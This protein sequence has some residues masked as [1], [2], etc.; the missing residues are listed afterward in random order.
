MLCQKGL[1][2][3]EFCNIWGLSTF[4]TNCTFCICVWTTL[5]T[6]KSLTYVTLQ[7]AA[8]YEK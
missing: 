6:V 5:Q 2:N 7:V 1:K 8:V 3:Y 4:F